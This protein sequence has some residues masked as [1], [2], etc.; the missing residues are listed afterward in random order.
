M[1]LHQGTQAQPP[2]GRNNTSPT[3]SRCGGG[4]LVGGGFKGGGG[5]GVVGA[6]ASVGVGRGAEG[7]RR[8][9]SPASFSRAAA[10]LPDRGPGLGGRQGHQRWASLG[11]PRQGSFALAVGAC[12]AF[13]RKQPCLQAHR[14]APVAELRGG[15][16]S[17]PASP[18][19]CG[20]P[21]SSVRLRSFVGRRSV[22]CRSSVVVVVVV[23]SWWW[24]WS[25]PRPRCRR[26]RRCRRLCRPPTPRGHL[27]WFRREVVEGPNILIG[28][29]VAHRQMTLMF[30]G[31]SPRSLGA[32]GPLRACSPGREPDTGSRSEPRAGAGRLLPGSGGAHP[33]VSISMCPG[34]REPS[35]THSATPTGRGARW[36]DSSFLGSCRSVWRAPRRSSDGRGWRSGRQPRR[37]DG[38][39]RSWGRQRRRADEAV[40]R[41]E[42]GRPN[43]GHTRPNFGECT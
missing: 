6:L 42:F 20:S 21:L 9:L 11:Q 1:L 8:T 5:V 30:S 16:L 37:A 41:P 27:H 40:R 4:F 28:G 35:H 38:R 23:L 39:V 2:S 22:V 15:Q 25:S 43:F 18:S 7:I 31:G 36:S 32:L 10:A 12:R 29:A 17:G 24:W 19:V 34:F 26:R 33:P 14:L 3:Q 13:G